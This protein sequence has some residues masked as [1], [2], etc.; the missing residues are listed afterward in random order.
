MARK[1]KLSLSAEMLK[2]TPLV[3]LSAVNCR[4]LCQL[5]LQNKKG[6][7]RVSTQRSLYSNLKQMYM[8]AFSYK[9]IHNT[10]TQCKASK[11]AANS[12]NFPHLRAIIT[13]H[14]VC[15]FKMMYRTMDAAA[16]QQL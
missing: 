4:Q 3:Q 5:A 2:S 6:S 15:T 16:Q 1:T 8:T 13:S 10:T 12:G 7:C 11:V 9:L 14:T